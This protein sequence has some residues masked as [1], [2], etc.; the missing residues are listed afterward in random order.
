MGGGGWGGGYC[1]K[2]AY[3]ASI[4]LVNSRVKSK[5]HWLDIRL[6]SWQRTKI[7]T[8]SKAPRSGPIRRRSVLCQL[9][10]QG[11]FHPSYI[12]LAETQGIIASHMK[13][14]KKGFSLL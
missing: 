13:C 1:I 2:Q 12:T 9:G 8:N 6:L 7:K 5:G 4:A 10:A 3:K 11:W 14:I